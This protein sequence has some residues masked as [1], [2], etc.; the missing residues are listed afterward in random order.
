MANVDH[1]SLA[2]Q[3][4]WNRE[5]LQLEIQQFL[6]VDWC[7]VELENFSVNNRLDGRLLEKAAS[8]LIK[9]RLFASFEAA[10]I[11]PADRMT[12]YSHSFGSVIGVGVQ[13]TEVQK[14][15]LSGLGVD[16]EPSDRTL[17]PRLVDRVVTEEEREWNLDPIQLWV[18][19][20]ACFKS[21][22]ENQGFSI[23]D[24]IV[25]ECARVSG[26]EYRID[27]RVSCLRETEM[28]FFFRLLK[29]EDRLLA[30]AVAQRIS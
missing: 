25:R 29:V 17:S 18:I 9:K 20:E 13:P 12:S 3:I 27:G 24:F 14:F 8:L 7:G 22:P 15:Y 1:P 30:L 6:G 21:T 2:T 26:K 11:L 23:T 4:L 19:K 28:L 10:Q 5:H 16:L